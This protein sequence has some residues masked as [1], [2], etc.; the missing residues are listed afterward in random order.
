MTRTR[1]GSD[2]KRLFD[3]A[4]TRAEADKLRRSLEAKYPGCRVAVRRARTTTR[5]R[6]AIYAGAACRIPSNK[7]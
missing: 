1:K 4:L 3:L 6:Y 7:R 2:K 5:Y